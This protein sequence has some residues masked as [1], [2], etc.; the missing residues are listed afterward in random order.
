MK[1]LMSPLP[2][3][4]EDR[5]GHSSIAS[6]R[7]SADVV[8]TSLSRFR[9]GHAFEDDDEIDAEEDK[10]SMEEFVQALSDKLKDF[11]DRFFENIEDR[12]DNFS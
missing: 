9:L 3:D 4:P 2:E 7:A 6:D 8:D 5:E 11:D 10:I 12:I 1:P